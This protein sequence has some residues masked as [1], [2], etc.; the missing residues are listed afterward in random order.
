[1]SKETPWDTPVAK[2]LLII[3]LIIDCTRC[4]HI[5]HLSNSGN[6]LT[7]AQL[8]P[9]EGLYSPPSALLTSLSP[10]A[11]GVTGTQVK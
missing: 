10:D 3:M 1:M 11:S 5:S 6:G 8:V 4:G 9:Q 2:W 7:L